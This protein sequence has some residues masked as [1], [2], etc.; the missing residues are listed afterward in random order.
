VHLHW[1]GH[2]AAFNASVKCDLGIAIQEG[3]EV[4][5]QHEIVPHLWLLDM[6]RSQDELN[7]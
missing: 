2:A 6:K 5:G 4:F 1:E 3:S 7:T